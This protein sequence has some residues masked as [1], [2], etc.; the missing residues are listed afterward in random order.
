MRRSNGGELSRADRRAM[1][2]ERMFEAVTD[3]PTRH[4]PE[5][6]DRELHAAFRR[7]FA[8]QQADVCRRWLDGREHGKDYQDFCPN[9]GLFQRIR[10]L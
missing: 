9:A 4:A 5:T 3:D 8:C 10:D 6:L 2:M 7:C 1:L